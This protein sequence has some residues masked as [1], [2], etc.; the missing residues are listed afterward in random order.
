MDAPDRATLNALA[1][2]LLHAAQLRRTPVPKLVRTWHVT[3]PLAAGLGD[4]AEWADESMEIYLKDSPLARR[5]DYVFP[6]NGESM[7][8]DFP[9]GCLVSVEAMRNGR[10]TP[11]AIGAF[12]TE[13]ALYIKVY[14][15]DG[16]YSLNPAF[17]PMLFADYDEIR[18]IG[19][20]NGIITPDDIAAEQE[21]ALFRELNGT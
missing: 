1:D 14:R 19:R 21:A 13:N 10:L 7:E 4:P 18:L 20:V 12:Q 9:S 2:Q 17:P 5:T 15:P 16:L 8:P 11:G 3:I 6:V